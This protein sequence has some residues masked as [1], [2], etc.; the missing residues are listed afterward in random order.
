MVRFREIKIQQNCA[1]AHA[2]I[3]KQFNQDRHLS[4]PDIFKQ[5]RSTALVK[6]RQFPT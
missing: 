4:R 1:S 5:N 3:H 6:W 2:S